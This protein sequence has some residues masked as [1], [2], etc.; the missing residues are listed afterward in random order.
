VNLSLLNTDWYIDQMRRRA[1]DS[2]PVPFGLA[3]EKYRQG[4]RDVVAMLPR[5]KDAGHLDLRKAM[6]FLAD[7][8]NMQL[9]FSRTQKDAYLPGY[10]FKIPV[11]SATV[12]TNGTLTVKDTADWVREVRWAITDQR[13]NPKQILM[14]NHLMVLDLLANNNWE[15][16]IYFAVTPGPDS[17]I[18]L[19]DHFRLEGLTYRLV[20][21][22]SRQRNPNTF[23]TVG[24]D[25]M[26]DNVMNKFKWG[27]MDSQEDIYLD[28]NILRMTT[29]LRLQI[30][31]LADAL[32][33]EGRKDD[34]KKVLDLSLEKMPERNVP[35]DRIMLPVIEA[36][37]AADDKATAAALADRLFTIMDENMAY[38][39]SLEPEFANKVDQEMDITIA[40]M[41][42][43]ATTTQLR[44][45][46]DPVT[47]RLKARMDEVA[48][49]YEAKR[50]E[51]EAADRRTVKMRF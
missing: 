23:G 32:A 45:P 13:G 44:D 27:N 40:V 12:F 20:P 14:K 48:M 28:E 7:D 30:A 43:L 31:T 5:D 41:Q 26:F 46:T 2:P 36:Y 21:K 47:E 49:L 1:Y 51:M 11:D 22:F 37:Y 4:T 33:A 16:P 29:N 18:N 39:L 8:R 3:P 25:V 24:T 35:Y 17:Y 9:L 19:Q 34:A 38:M 50:E 15:R 10:K 42:R 6:A